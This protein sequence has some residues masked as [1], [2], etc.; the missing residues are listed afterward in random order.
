MNAA[1]IFLAALGLANAGV[2]NANTQA[3]AETMRFTI[4]RNDDPIGT[5]TIEINRTGT[6]TTVNITTELAVN[7]L[8]FTAYHLEQKANEWWIDGHLA[9]LHSI[10]DNN[11]AR[12]KVAVM[13][14]GSDLELD[15]D[16]KKSRLDKDVVPAS[17]WN[18]EFLRHSVVLDPQDGQVAPIRVVDGGLERLRVG[19]RTLQAHHYTVKG[20][21]SQDVW[22]DGRGGLVR[23]KIVGSDGS[24]ILYKPA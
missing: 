10:T 13:M 18:P 19:N 16:G 20:R 7:V 8:F 9:A 17:L 23:V 14:K 24:V 3:A 1:Y 11:G 6:E 2:A 21:Y 5:H 12:H 22:Y 15:A 4:T